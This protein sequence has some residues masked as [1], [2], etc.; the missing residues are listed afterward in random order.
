MSPVSYLLKLICTVYLFTLAGHVLASQT[1]QNDL[2]ELSIEELLNVEIINASRLGQDANKAPASI[3]VLTANEIRTFGWRTLAEAL[4]AMRGLYT[5]NDRN[6]S[7]LGV[8]GFQHPNDYNSRVLIMIDGQRMNENLYDGGYIAQ[9]FMLDVGLI[10]R[11]EFIPGSGSSIYGANAFSGLINVVTKNG[12]AI[13]GAQIAGQI[14]SFDTYKGR[15]SYGKKLENGADILVSAS[16]YDSAGVENLYFQEFD[17]PATNNGIAHNMDAERADRLFGK[18]QFEEFTLSAGYV[19]R[20]KRIPTAS[21]GTIFNDKDTHTTDQQFFSNLTYQK[22]LNDKNA[23]RLKG[24]Y[25]G[26]SYEGAYPYD[27]GGRIVNHDAA[28]GR[29]WG[30]EAQLTSTAFEHHRLV[31][32]LEYQY[33]QRQRQLNYD[34]NPY[35]L[36]LDSH[37]N[38]HRLELYA[39]DDF[40]FLDDWV[41]SAG[42]RLDYHHMLKNLQLNPR[43]GLIW[44]PLDNTTFKLLYS[45]SFRAPNA[46]ERDYTSL[47]NTPNPNNFE[48]RIKSYEGVVEWRST[49]GL[50]LIGD[51]FYNEMT[52]ILEQTIEPG[53]GATGQFINKDHYHAIGFELEAEQ[54]W[55]NGRYF[56]ASYTFSRLT[57]ESDGGAW[58]PASPQ[59]MFK[60]HY[61]EPLFD[62]FAKLGIE[63]IFIDDRRTSQTGVADAYY[64]LNLNLSTDRIAPG[65]DVSLGAYNLFDSHYQMLG[66]TGI[67]DISQNILRMNGREFRLKIQLTY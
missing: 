65:L 19:D 29:W 55:N 30:G 20:Y 27:D 13:N 14:G 32:G 62:N 5:S 28:S 46:W 56:K 22:N 10:E 24:F 53:S 39:Q 26:Y 42:L 9:E 59:N 60:L 21:F 1:N 43:L 48:E 8:R 44:N 36:Y 11:I 25:Q 31:L 41:F 54:R 51:F 64:Q 4:N 38:G 3:S 45:S 49:G 15:A 34:A 66:G 37:R 16:H 2:T 33:D 61:A 6:Y 57:N 63:N 58:A 40:E 52:Q 47:V 50:K 7:Y 35:T 17:S 18:V 67:N 12:S 23:L